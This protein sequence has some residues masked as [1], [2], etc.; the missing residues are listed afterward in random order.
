MHVRH[1]WFNFLI[2]RYAPRP[3]HTSPLTMLRVPFSAYT[4]LFFSAVLRFVVTVFF[5]AQDPAAA[6]FGSDRPEV[7]GGGGTDDED[8]GSGAGGGGGGG[9]DGGG[10]ARDI[11]AV[12]ASGGRGVFYVESKPTQVRRR[13]IRNCFFRSMYIAAE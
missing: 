6:M 3:V 4:T 2:V 12:R 11:G 8:G 5:Q 10:G 9:G 13:T 1:R 7:D